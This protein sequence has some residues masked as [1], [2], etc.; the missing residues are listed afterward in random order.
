MQQQRLLDNQQE[1]GMGRVEENRRSDSRGSNFGRG[2]DLPNYRNNDIIFI[3]KD[4]S[5]MSPDGDV[6][7]SV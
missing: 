1:N 7:K 4:R 5:N 2:P 6:N 3:D